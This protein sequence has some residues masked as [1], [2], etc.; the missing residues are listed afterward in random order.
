MDNQASTNYALT[1]PNW[2]RDNITDTPYITYTSTMPP[3]DEEIKRASK[4]LAI[5]AALKYAKNKTLSPDNFMGFVN[6][7]Y[8][9]LVKQ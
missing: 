9:F 2:V 4:E 6:Q 8:E 7:I 3:S 1:D 5:H